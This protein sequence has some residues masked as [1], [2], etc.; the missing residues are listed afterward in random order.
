MKKLLL[1]LLVSFASNAQS[2]LQENFDA[3]GSPIALP[4]GWEMTNQSSPIGTGNWFAGNTASF[5]SYNGPDNGYIAVNYQSG[6]GT[7]TLSN[8]LMTPPVTVQNGDEVSFYTRVP[9]GSTWADRLELRQ[10]VLGASSTAP[11]GVNDVGSYSTLCLTVNPNLVAS[12]YPSTWTKYTYVVA[13]LTGQ[14]SCRFALRYTVPNG[15]PSGA[16]SNYV[17]VDAFQV[18][19]LVANDLSLNSVTVPAIITAGNYTFNGVVENLGTNAVT[20]YQVTWQAN[21]GAINSYDVTGVNIAPGTTHNFTH[22]LPLNAVVGQSYA[23]NFNVSLVNAVVDGDPSN[24]TLSRSTQV[25]SGTTTY[26]PMIEKFTSSTCNPCASYNGSTFNPYYTA[27]NQTFNYVAYQ[28][29]WPGAGD[30][31]YFAEAGVRRAY[32][33]V[34]AITSLW[35]DGSEYST[36]NNQAALTAHVNNEATKPGY[37]GLTA[38]R[39]FSN[40]T[41]LVNYNITPYISGDYVLHAAVIELVTTNNAST[42]G[43]TS[44][45]HVMMK[46]V[47]DASGTPVT[48]TAGTP[49][50]GQVSAS[51]AGT[52]IEQMT[53]LEV[54]VFLQNPVTKEIV[55][56]YKATDVLSTTKN[57]IETVKVYPNPAQ[58][59]IKISNV[60][61]VNVIITD[62]TG[63]T[64]LNINNVSDATDINVSGLNS[65]IYFVN[66][67]NEEVN[68]TIKF[69]KK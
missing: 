38:S 42:N 34:N 40:N 7:S 51:L 39:D 35:I 64:V 65:G 63:K 44:F 52:F 12:Q 54:I 37:F 58:D 48:L 32:Y 2:L 11:V 8:W 4:T 27:Q 33:G 13:G 29:N 69:I 1:L 20:S 22:S 41:A 10:S 62:V 5:T 21:S 66:V 61:D 16:N 25:A 43:E 56:S 28:M 67:S 3:L 57:N 15:G 14:V 50:G 18:K 30:P 6:S 31:Y 49:V 53:D 17:G 45:K 36:Q 23:L 46:M 55:Q 47:P 26:K 9:D 24:N 59:F 68:Q 60:E 19:R